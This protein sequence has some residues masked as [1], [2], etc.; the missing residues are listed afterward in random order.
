[1]RNVVFSEQ[2]GGRKAIEDEVEAALRL[3]LPASFAETLDLPLPVT[4]AVRFSNQASFHPVR[5]LQGLAA[6]LD[7]EELFES[8]TAVGVERG[9]PARVHT[10]TGAVVTANQVV[11]A[12]HTPFLDRGLFFA[13]VHPE[14]S[15]AA[16]PARVPAESA[17]AAMY[18]STSSP[19]STVRAHATDGDTWLVVGGHGHKTGQADEREA[20]ARLADDARSRFGLERLELHWA[21][22]DAGPVDKVPFVGPVEPLARN[23]HVVT[24]MRKW[25]LAMGTAGVLL[26][27]LI[28]ERA[29]PWARLFS[30]DRIRARAGAFDFAK[31]NANVGW[32][33]VADRVRNRGSAGELAPGEGAVVGAG[34]GQRALFRDDDGTLHALSARCTHLG[35]IVK[36]N[37]AERSWDCPCHGSRFAHDGQVLEGPATSPLPPRPE[38]DPPAP[39]SRRPP[40]AGA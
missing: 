9:S 22:Q 25:G 10:N 31:Q 37:A 23:V 18:L 20:Y 21:T 11:V 7:E 38:P 2:E 34:L 6:A 27:D 17:P 16:V 24:G 4:G 35:C 29:N 12:T 39:R 8:T 28:A 1:V 19:A 14:R 32:H 36:W 33:F 13:R 5:Y 26:S 30:T 3:G 40:P 15:Y